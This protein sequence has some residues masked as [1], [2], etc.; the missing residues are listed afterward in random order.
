M[1]VTAK[2][3]TIDQRRLH[4]GRTS[5]QNIGLESSGF[6]V[7]EFVSMATSL[8]VVGIADT[9]AP[10]FLKTVTKAIGKTCIEPFLDPIE[11]TVSGL[12]KLEE[13]KIDKTKSREQRAEDLAYTMVVFS[14]A[15]AASM[16]AKIQ[17]RRGMNRLLGI[18]EPLHT[19]LFK[20]TKAEKIIIGL[21]EGVHYGSL[22]LLNTSAAHYTDD[23]IRTTTGL[24]QK[25]GLPER[26]AKELSSMAMIW[27]LPNI[28]G[29]FAGIG[30]IV[31]KHKHG[32]GQS[33]KHVDKLVDQTVHTM[34]THQV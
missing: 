17:T 11:N 4:N 27:E 28:L 14:T 2:V 1:L 30:G 29:L 7:A 22:L 32:W 25:L 9:I 13:C 5:A 6:A 20:L 8:G 12:C 18:E 3:P 16:L 15:W 33:K 19:S 24:L 34:P 23:M 26:K 10:G 21:D 31:G